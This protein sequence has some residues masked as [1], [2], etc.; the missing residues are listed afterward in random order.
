MAVEV[1]S[2]TQPGEVITQWPMGGEKR[3]LPIDLLDEALERLFKIDGMKPGFGREA[4][5][6]LAFYLLFNV[7]FFIFQT[8]PIMAFRILIGGPSTIVP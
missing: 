6:F 2:G 3:A 8:G 4:A 7:V 1:A 5:R